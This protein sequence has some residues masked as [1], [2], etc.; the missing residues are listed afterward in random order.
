MD[1]VICPYQSVG[2][3]KFGMPREDVRNLINSGFETLAGIELW[4]RFLNLGLQVCYSYEPPHI[5]E[6]ILLESTESVT[7]LDRQLLGGESISV[8]R[9]WLN[10]LDSELHVDSDDVTTY[11][12]GFSLSRQ[13][14]DY[15]LFQLPPEAVT[16]FREGYYNDLRN[17]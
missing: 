1:F 14:E 11:K 8:L 17:T 12:Y 6:A 3:I 7:F 5:C 4:E 9:D 2:S 13:V 15:G 10:T 16:C